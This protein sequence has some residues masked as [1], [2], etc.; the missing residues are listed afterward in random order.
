MIIHGFQ[1]LTMLDFPGKTA[2]TVF[3]GG[4]NMRCPFCHNA[5][6]VLDPGAYPVIPEEEVIGLL[7]RRRGILDGVCVT[8]GEPMLQKD[9]P[10]FAEKIKNL[11]FLVKIDTN[12]TFPSELRYMLNE[13]LCDYVAMD[14]KNSPAKYGETVGRKGFDI[15]RIIE[16]IDVLKSTSVPHEFRTTVTKT[17]HEYGDLSE[18]AGM[19]GS[20][21]NY[22]LQAYRASDKVMDGTVT[23]YLPSELREMTARLASEH[24]DMNISLRG[25]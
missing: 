16:S 5:D 13:G 14:V 8:G 11:G 4:C 10:V 3:T 12:G 22:Y 21:Q 24:A 6:L 20:G 1:K 17:F 7:S 15:S 2:C 23:G 25:V 18:I 19:L 9:L